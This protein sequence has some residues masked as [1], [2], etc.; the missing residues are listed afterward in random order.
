M[1]L[2]N[3]VVIQYH[4]FHYNTAGTLGRWRE[5][6]DRGIA[7]EMSDTL[8]LAVDGEETHSPSTTGTF[9]RLDMSVRPLSHTRTPVPAWDSPTLYHY[10]YH[11]PRWDTVRI[12]PLLGKWM[13]MSTGLLTATAVEEM[14]T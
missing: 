3:S 11:Y 9:Q 5:A 4:Y 1:E 13:Q 6:W 7:V 2:R 8:R 14:A 10:H 12:R